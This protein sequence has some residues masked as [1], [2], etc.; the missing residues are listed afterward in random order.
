MRGEKGAIKNRKHGPGEITPK[1]K[2]TIKGGKG[3]YSE[4]QT[5]KKNKS[6]EIANAK[7]IT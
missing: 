3:Y 2:E 6:R 5:E 7:N 1:T 4:V